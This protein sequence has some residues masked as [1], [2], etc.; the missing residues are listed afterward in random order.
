MAMGDFVGKLKVKEYNSAKIKDDKPVLVTQVRVV[1]DRED[2]P[3]PP[4]IEVGGDFVIKSGKKTLLKYTIPE[5]KK[6]QCRIA[7]KGKIED[8][9]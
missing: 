4:F 1:G 8:V 9:E 3:F 7:I 2:M 6:L 5:G